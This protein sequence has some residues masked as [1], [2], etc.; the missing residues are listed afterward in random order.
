MHENFSSPFHLFFHPNPLDFPYPGT[1][2]RAC[3]C[4]CGGLDMLALIGEEI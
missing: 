1:S 4:V 2:Q 3:V